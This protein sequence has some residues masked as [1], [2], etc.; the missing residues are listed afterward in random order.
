MAKQTLDNLNTGLEFRTK[1][2]E[3]FTEVYTSIANLPNKTVKFTIGGVGVE[4]CDFN[5]LTAEDQVEQYIEVFTLPSLGRISQA[6]I[7]T[8]EAFDN[9]VSLSVVMGT[10]NG[11]DDIIEAIDMIANNT[12]MSTSPNITGIP[13]PTVGE[14]LLIVAATPGA[15]WSLNSAGKLTVYIS[16][17]DITNV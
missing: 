2:N 3:N 15:N 17:I 6:F 9:L 11:D 8:T 14:R 5:F 4:D 12:I 10:S 13:A 1:L 7:I 16:Y